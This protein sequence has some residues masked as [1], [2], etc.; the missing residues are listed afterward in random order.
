[1]LLRAIA[2][3]S[4][5][6]AI[7]LAVAGEGAAQQS[8][9]LPN[10]DRRFESEQSP[11]PPKE[12]SR[13]K[14]PAVDDR[15]PEDEAIQPFILSGVVIEGASAFEVSAFTTAYEEFLAKQVGSAEIQTIVQRVTRTYTD[16]GYFLSRAI[17]P[18][19][20]IVGGLIRIRVIEGFFKKVT[21]AGAYAGKSA[22]QRYVAPIRAARPANMAALERA[23]FLMNDMAGLTIDPSVEALD[24]ASG[25]Y[26][27]VIQ[28]GQKHVDAFARL[29]NR[30]TPEVGR[31]QGWLGAS[32]NSLFGLGER[33]GATFITVPSEPEEL[34]YGAVSSDIPVGAYGTLLS[35]FGAYSTID[36]GS[37]SE[38][39][40]S[41][42]RSYQFIGRLSHPLIRSKE[43]NLW[44]NGSF[45][46]RNFREKQFGSTVISDRL[47]TLRLGASYQ[48]QDRFKGQTRVGVGVSQGLDI[49]GASDNGSTERSRS[50]GRNDFTKVTGDIVR[51]QTITELVAVQ[52]GVSGQW[53]A[54]PLLS[55]EEFPVGGEQ[56]G[57][58][59]DFSEI[60]G[61]HGVAGSVEL[62][63][64]RRSK[65][66]WLDE[67]QFYGFYD[68]GAVW[69]K[70]SGNSDIR[71]SLSSAGAG[72]RVKLFEKLQA[73]LEAAKP[74]DRDVNTEDD[75]DWRFFFTTTVTY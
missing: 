17:A 40:D 34:L 28:L 68:I 21:F 41:E 2:A 19:Q 39:L 64:G 32:V 31:L 59:Y 36:A 27:L 75:N 14:L 55:Y 43:Q 23:L 24:E 13:L 42:S 8:T 35:L 49:F 46:F 51:R 73:N 10:I 29:D 63:V 9:D 47:R 30:G 16:A 61:E 66:S 72:M 5:F 53:A 22:L 45:D 48:V 4:L 50:N 52:A 20:D 12:R 38:P 54:V 18:A 74:L 70:V 71:S 37:S 25:E 44:I 6:P 65:W 33:I 67:Y 15:R 57:R 60:S 3:C 7:V 56:F 69:N 11:K 26:E 58:A 1:L 62:Q